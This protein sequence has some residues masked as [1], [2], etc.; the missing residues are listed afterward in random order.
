MATPF[1][2]AWVNNAGSIVAS[3][4]AIS[5][6]ETRLRITSACMAG[7][8]FA[9]ISTGTGVFLSS[10][11]IRYRPTHGATEATVA[12]WPATIRSSSASRPRPRAR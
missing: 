4:A 3:V 8:S 10:T 12:A 6:R 11:D 2:C 5:S 9:A 7:R 1:C